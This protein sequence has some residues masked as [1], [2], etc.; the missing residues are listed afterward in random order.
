LPGWKEFLKTTRVIPK[1]S[2][3]QGA[4]DSSD[5]PKKKEGKKCLEAVSKPPIRWLEPFVKR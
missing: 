5:P 4:K 3:G 2:W 1:G